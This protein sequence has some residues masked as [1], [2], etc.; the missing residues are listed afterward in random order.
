MSTARDEIPEA[1]EKTYFSISEVAR[2][3]KVEQHVLRYWERRFAELKPVKRGGGRRYYRRQDV[4]LVRR[5][6]DLLHEQGYTI[7]GARRRL[8]GGEGDARP[9]SHN[10]ARGLREELQALL[11]ELK[12]R[13]GA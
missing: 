12:R 3:C 5:I 4:L 8:S 13:H 9:D 11:A 6:R 7:S 10:L 1:G 2:I